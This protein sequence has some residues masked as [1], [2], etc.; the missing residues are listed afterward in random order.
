MFVWIKPP[1]ICD[2]QLVISARADDTTF[3]ILHSRFHELWSLRLGT[4]LE[5]RPRYTPSSTFETFPFPEGLTLTDTKGQPVAEGDLLFPPVTAEHLPAAVKIASAAQ[6]LVT[7][8]DNWLNPAEWVE[9]VPEVAEG[10][11]ERIVAKPEHAAELKKR[12][13]TNLYNARP[14]WLDNAHK[15]LDKAVAEAYGWGDYDT[16]MSDDEVLRRLLALNVERSVA[17]SKEGAAR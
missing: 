16:D 2:G 7:L 11:P 12:T 10:Y 9:R 5:D 15:A 1:V 6:R 4:A 8:R 3:G 13:L 14:A 17:I